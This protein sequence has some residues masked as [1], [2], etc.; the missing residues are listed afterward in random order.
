[1]VS[2]S[3]NALSFYC[4]IISVSWYFIG[5]ANRNDVVF[6]FYRS[7]F[8]IEWGKGFT[9]EIKSRYEIGEWLN[10]K[11]LIEFG[12]EIGTFNGWFAS[13][14]LHLWRGKKLYLID[15]W[16]YLEY[17][18]DKMN[19]GKEEQR[20]R[21]CNTFEMIY[22]FGRRVVMIRELSEDAGLLFNNHSLD[23]VYIDAD[24]SYESVFRDIQLWASKVKSGGVLIGH[25]YLDGTQ[26]NGTIYSVKSAVNDWAKENLKEVQIIEEDK[27]HEPG[28]IIYL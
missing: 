20:N 14:I 12:V 6:Y 13:D 16:R 15:A 25:D 5:H 8:T 18:N 26:L 24:H 1:M 4:S 27:N 3:T 10:E 17:W 28:W 11:G 2:N 9:V 7:F 23:F 19:A 22:K 21:L